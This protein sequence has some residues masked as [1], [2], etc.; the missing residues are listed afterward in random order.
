MI[1]MKDWDEIKNLMSDLRILQVFFKSLNEK[2]SK[3]TETVSILVLSQN[4]NFEISKLI[5]IMGSDFREKEN[6]LHSLNFRSDI[7]ICDLCNVDDI[8]IDKW[9]NIKK[10][11]KENGE[12]LERGDENV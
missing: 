1:N 2:Y 7:S 8:F 10:M 6:R 12:I 9:G 3:G 4:Y 11:V 5:K